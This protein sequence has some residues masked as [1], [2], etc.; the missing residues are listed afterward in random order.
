MFCIAGLARR[1]EHLLLLLHFFVSIH[2]LDAFFCISYI[3]IYFAFKPLDWRSVTAR[4]WYYY[5]CFILSIFFILVTE[6]LLL[7]SLLY[8]HVVLLLLFSWG[9]VKYRILATRC[10]VI[11]TILLLL[12][13]VLFHLNRSYN[14]S[15]LFIS[16][17]E[18]EFSLCVRAIDKL[19]QMDFSIQFNNHFLSQCV[20]QKCQNISEFDREKNGPTMVSKHLQNS[21]IHLDNGISW[22][23]HLQFIFILKNY[24]IH[25]FVVPLVFTYRLQFGLKNNKWTQNEIN[26][27]Y[28]VSLLFVDD[29]VGFSGSLYFTAKL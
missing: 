16:W 9:F 28:T 4:C 14:D 27:H 22:H 19:K 13:F 5:Y 7:G 11:A 8:A 24:I 3:Y 18:N 25:L 1:L 6:N 17:M 2:F 26:C 29:E 20:R 10:N 21:G 12:F 23:I 15:F